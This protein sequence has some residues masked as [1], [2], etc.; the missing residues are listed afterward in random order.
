[1]TGAALAA[2]LRPALA[3]TGRAVDSVTSHVAISL[4]TIVAVQ[5]GLTVVLFFSVER[6]GW[7]TYQGGDQLWL[8]T[9][10]WLLG[11]GVLPYALV[12]Y[13]WPVLMAPLTWLSGASS[14]DLLPYTT[15]FQVAV[16]GPI[17]TLAVYDIGARIAGRFAGLWCASAWVLA[18]Y[19]ASALFVDRYQD[20]F[21]EQVIVQMVG[22]TQLADYPSTVL[23]LIAAAFVIRSLDAGAI[24]EA[25]LAGAVAGLA[26]GVKPANCLFLAGPA[27]AYLLARRWRAAAVFAVSL[28]PAVVVLL[29]WKVRGTG[30]IP[31]F[32]AGTVHLASS[33]FGELPLANSFLER[34]PL[35]LEDWERNM[36]NLREFFW[37]A[38][39]AQW[40]PLAGALAVARRSVPAAGLL[41]GWLLGYVLVKGSSPL[42][43]IESGSFWRLVMPAF[44]A[45]VLLA[46]A[47][48]LLVP[49]VMVRVA[50]RVAPSPGRRPGRR[51]VVVAVTLLAALPA[52]FVLGASPERGGAHAIEVNGILV[53]VDGETV[54]VRTER[55]GDA[56]HLAWDDRTSP[57][58]PFYRVYRTSGTEPDLRC[59]KSTDR[60]SLEMILLGTTRS[61]KWVDASPE[62]GVAY[63]IG[64][65]ANWV[66]DPEQGDVMLI[67]PSIRAAA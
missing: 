2:R 31:L 18:P 65:A 34:F 33:A 4:G 30:S 8:V 24:R 35:N 21:T 45:Y 15:L 11:Q 41:L 19:V 40:A 20:R 57:T 54:R 53:P 39:L 46:A 48:P 52:A 59:A 44:P 43:S 25:A 23:V 10:G 28:L 64:V 37:G 63:R 60:C 14:L 56:Q 7:L 3:V 12:G 61:P 32:A 51:T 49:T 17:A 27:L 5:V 36:S 47:I 29:I 9:T 6:N 26:L 58:K 1:M 62:P 55:V 16:L 66:D 13:G 42:A 67:S 38:R 22:L 50:A